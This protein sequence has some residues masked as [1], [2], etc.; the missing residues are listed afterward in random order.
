MRHVEKD[1]TKIPDKLK[2]CSDNNEADLIET[3]EVKA[4]CYKKSKEKLEEIYHNKCAFCDTKYGVNTYTE[5]EHYRP[6]AQNMYYWLAYEWSNLVP[7]CRKC[8]NSKLDKFPILASKILIPPIE[9]GKLDKAK[10]L[11]DS[12]FLLNEQPYI[13]HPE[14]DN[15][16][17]FFN[18]KI[19]E[20]KKGI[21]INGFDEKGRGNKTIDAC[22]L[23]REE[24]ILDRQERVIDDIVESI[25]SILD[26]EIPNE[27]KKRLFEIKINNLSQ[28]AENPELNHTLLRKFIISKPDNFKK[29]IQP[30]F[31]TE[32][33]KH[34]I[35]E[36]ADQFLQQN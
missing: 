3:K 8:N 19:D 35:S 21:K 23:N 27:I 2:V 28:K 15:P 4:S 29:I 14:I 16:E 32:N 9:N 10:C 12:D 11:A 7:A 17:E 18:F 6:K 25:L 22:V 36:I 13:L 24:L 1:F 31:E 5:V 26:P 34:I 20:N 33:Q 30:Y